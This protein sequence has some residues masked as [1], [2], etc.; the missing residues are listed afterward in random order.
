MG[1][2]S[3]AVGPRLDVLQGE[4][5]RPERLTLPTVLADS[6]L[7]AGEPAHQVWLLAASLG[8]PEAVKAFMDAL[9]GGLPVGFVYAQHIEASFE[10]ALSLSLIHI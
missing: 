1:D 7:R 8:G 6:A 10:S 4:G 5:Q 2:P 3:R 9:P